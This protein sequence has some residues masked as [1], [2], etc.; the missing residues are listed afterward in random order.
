MFLWTDIFLLYL[1]YTGLAAAN[2]DV[3]AFNY[4]V[5]PAFAIDTVYYSITSWIDVLSLS[6]ILSNSSMQQTPISAKTR[7]PPSK[8]S[9]FVTGSLNTAAVNPTPDE[10]LPVV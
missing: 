4:V 9:S 7:A 1:P 3:L 10:P 8:Q 2:T 5:I 6:S